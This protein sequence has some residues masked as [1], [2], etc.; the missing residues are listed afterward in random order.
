MRSLWLGVLAFGLGACAGGD[1]TDVGDTDVADTDGSDTDGSDTDVA[2]SMLESEFWEGVGVAACEIMIEDECEGAPEFADLDECLASVNDMMGLPGDCGDGYD[3]TFA[4]AC[5]ADIRAL[6]CSLIGGDTEV[7]A[8]CLSACPDI[9][10]GDDTD[11]PSD[12]D[13]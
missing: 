7:P 13:G 10:G 2:E 5:L 4:A 8:S 12:T 9:D 3:G 1:D 11:P 6:S